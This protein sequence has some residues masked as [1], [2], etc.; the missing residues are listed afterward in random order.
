MADWLTGSTRMLEQE[1]VRD[2][3]GAMPARIRELLD[4]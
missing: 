3:L 1:W 4:S 2:Q